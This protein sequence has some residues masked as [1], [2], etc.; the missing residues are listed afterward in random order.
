[1][2]VDSSN[3][4]DDQQNLDSPVH[5]NGLSLSFFS[6]L[7][8]RTSTMTL[9]FVLIFLGIQLAVVDSYLLTPRITHFLSQQESDAAQPAIVS[10][11]IQR[12]PYRQVA[13]QPLGS[14]R[15]VPGY[16]GAVTQQRVTPPKWLC[17]PVL[18]CGTVVLLQGA[19]MKRD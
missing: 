4:K 7:M 12:N 6:M 15:P 9:G 17:W 10:N 8:R 19:T 3:D 2:P 5:L 11:P 16:E 13:F 14:Q 1:M 18:F